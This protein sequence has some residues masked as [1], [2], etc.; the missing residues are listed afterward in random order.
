MQEVFM[1]LIVF[2]TTFGIVYLFFTTRHRERMALIEKGAD[3]TLFYSRKED[4]LS[5]RKKRALSALKVG[6]VLVGMAFGVLL[7]TI[8]TAVTRLEEAPVY[9]G[10]ILFFGGI[11]LI[12]FYIYDKKA[13]KS[14][15]QTI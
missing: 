12:G 2:I 11:G 1:T 6:M 8:L 10:S 15:N 7:A 9:I 13:Q 14:D 3:A 4:N 5:M